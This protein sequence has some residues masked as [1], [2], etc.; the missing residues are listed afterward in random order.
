MSGASESR[1]DA[2]FLGLPRPFA[3]VLG[4][5]HSAVWVGVATGVGYLLVAAA[6]I[7]QTDLATGASWATVLGDQFTYA[8]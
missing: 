8:L 4:F 6:V 2:H 5:R 7:S 1:D 3:W